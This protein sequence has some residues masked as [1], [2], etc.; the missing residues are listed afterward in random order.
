V[1][2]QVK[3]VRFGQPAQHTHVEDHGAHPPARKCQA[4]IA[5]LAETLETAP[6]A[7]IFHVFMPVP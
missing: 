4:N 1:F 5:G 7:T 2:D 3:P 6:S